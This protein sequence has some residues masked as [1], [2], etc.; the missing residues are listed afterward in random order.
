[1]VTAALGA[2]SSR[3]SWSSSWST[4]LYRPQP[5]KTSESSRQP[6]PRWPCVIK[7]AEERKRPVHFLRDLLGSPGFAS[8]ALLNTRRTMT[9]RDGTHTLSTSLVQ[10]LPAVRPR[11]GIRGA[12]VPSRAFLLFVSFECELDSFNEGHA[13]VV[14]DISLFLVVCLVCTKVC[15]T[16]IASASPRR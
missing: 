8:S 6:D 13:I 14:D 9:P 4:E 10:S 2:S 7:P 11:A 3:S 16:C 12:K 15:R 1:M 5:R